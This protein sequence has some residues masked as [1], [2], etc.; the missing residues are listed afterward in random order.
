MVCQY[1]RLCSLQVRISRKYRRC[2]LSGAINQRI[3]HVQHIALEL[4]QGLSGEQPDIQS[5]LV[6]AAATGVQLACHGTDAVGKCPLDVE[7]DVFAIEPEHKGA[8][9]YLVTDRV[10]SL[11]DLLSLVSRDDPL[12][13]Q[14]LRVGNASRDVFFREALIE[15]D[16]SVE[17]LNKLV[18]GFLEASAPRTV[19]AHRSVSY[20][21]SILRSAFCTCSL[22][23]A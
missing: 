4:L 14:H 15:A 12:S 21:T 18:E 22:F 17:S 7:V 9:S 5:H 2:V 10:K 13:G 8:G 16:R 23:S 20:E 1:D 3:D 6:V 19:C 11:D